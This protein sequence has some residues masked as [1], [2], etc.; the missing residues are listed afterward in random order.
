MGRGRGTR[1]DRSG[2]PRR[3]VH[4]HGL[5]VRDAL[6]HRAELARTEQAAPHSRRRQPED[7]RVRRLELRAG[8]R[9]RL[10]RELRGPGDVRPVPTVLPD[11]RHRLPQARDDRADHHRAH[12]LRRRHAAGPST[13]RQ[14][15]A[16]TQRGAADR[17]CRV[18]DRG[19]RGAGTDR[20]LGSAAGAMS[21]PHEMAAGASDAVVPE[22]AALGTADHTVV[23][24]RHGRRDY[25]I[26]RLL[27]GADVAGIVLAL[28]VTAAVDPFSG[29][30]LDI[31]AWGFVTLP[32]WIV[33]FKLYGLYDRDLKRVSH[34]TVDD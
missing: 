15:V 12:R 18:L 2:H 23:G 16:R 10:R 33:I 9:V 5:S 1:V 6:P 3:R 17:G 14:P 21:A 30:N 13:R 28:L 25:V 32:M 7:G 22:L 4:R 11:G 26:R 24:E 8:A 27:V 34:S 29:P 20:E 31:V 19:D